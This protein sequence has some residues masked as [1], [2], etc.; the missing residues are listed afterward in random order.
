MKTRKEK[1]KIVKD[2][3]EKFKKTKGYLLVSLLN[4]NSY[5]QVKIK[6]LLKENNSLFQVV[7]KTLIYKAN[8]EFPF[9]DEELKM[10]FA[11]IWDFDEN[12]GSLKALKELKN[13]GIELNIFSGYLWN[14]VF[15]KEEINQIINLPS[16]EELIKKLI[17]N[18]KNQIYRLDFALNF[19]LKKLVFLLSKIKK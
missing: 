14:R 18:L 3:V 8:P 7:K 10:P 17:S 15:N 5:Q 12:L 6:N 4:L 9:S 2:L 13:E 1:E 16:K 11:L 19:P